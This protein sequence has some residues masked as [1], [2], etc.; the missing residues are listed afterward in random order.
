MGPVKYNGAMMSATRK[1]N[2]F[3][4]VVSWAIAITFTF[5]T[6]VWGAQGPTRYTQTQTEPETS[7][8]A[9]GL[10]PAGAKTSPALADLNAILKVPLSSQIGTVRESFQGGPD[11]LIIHIQD[12][13]A[14]YEVQ[15]NYIKILTEL[16]KFAG[17]NTINFVAVEGAAGTVDTARL[18]TFPDKDVRDAIALSYLKKGAITGSEY[19]TAVLDGSVTVCG[20]ED[21]QMYIKNLD[22]YR[23][24]QTSRELVQSQVENLKQKL[25]A[26]ESRIYTPYQ[27]EVASK[28]D[29]Y[30]NDQLNFSDYCSVL[31]DACVKNGISL[32][33]YPNLKKALEAFK[34]E[35]TINMKLVDIERAGLLEKIQKKV[36]KEDSA[37]LVTR[38]LMFRVGR[39]SAGEYYRFLESMAVK[40]K[41]NLGAYPNLQKYIAVSALYETMQKDKMQEETAKA[42]EAV[43]ARVF[44]GKDQQEFAKLSKNFRILEHML[45]LKMSRDEL[46]YFKASR[47][48]FTAMWFGRLLIGLTNRNGLPPLAVS[49]FAA[50]IE[51][52]GKMTEFYDIALKRDD[53]IVENTLQQMQSRDFKVGVLV[54]GGF[55]TRGIAERLH[56]KNISY[57]VIAPTTSGPYDDTYYKQIMMDDLTPFERMLSKSG[58]RLA[59]ALVF[60]DKPLADEDR[61]DVTHLEWNVDTG[62]MFTGLA[63]GDR[64][65]EE[66]RVLWDQI[67]AKWRAA[68]VQHVTDRKKRAELSEAEATAKIAAFDADL[69]KIKVNVEEITYEKGR[70]I[71][72]PFDVAGVPEG[73]ARRFIPASDASP[74]DVKYV[75]EQ[76]MITMAG[77]E[78]AS[79]TLTTKA[80]AALLKTPAPGEG[81]VYFSGELVADE[82]GNLVYTLSMEPEEIEAVKGEHFSE[83]ENIGRYRAQDMLSILNDLFRQDGLFGSRYPFQD[84][85][86]LIK[87][88]RVVHRTKLGEL[89]DLPGNTAQMMDLYEGL[90]CEEHK[91]LLARVVAH[92]QIGH[93]EMNRLIEEM[94]TKDPQKRLEPLKKI[95]GSAQAATRK[96]IEEAAVILRDIQDFMG[97]QASQGA[98]VNSL[99][100]LEGGGQRFYH[101]YDDIAQ[102]PTGVA[103]DYMGK[104]MDIL[105]DSALYPDLR[106][107]SWDDVE[108]YAEM[109]WAVMKSRKRNWGKN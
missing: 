62:S 10:Q 28:L 18:R 87:G 42:E 59:T 83:L 72:I 109:V 9:P 90:I 81:K 94:R 11:K 16:R 41:M 60:A 37:A 61:V 92:E 17:A 69:G 74:D 66:K 104:V 35:A 96:A 57:M 7:A 50:A 36:V 73:F 79:Q 33:E 91:E 34:I 13:H 2:L 49:D 85:T 56:A 39:I 14:N 46:A 8:I 106:D 80:L 55:H 97:D 103:I 19:F 4:R 43:G 101:M 31:G 89:V 47:G 58:N 5:E 63:L 102:A 3:V 44:A 27:K 12:S 1:H 26:L 54:T 95:R 51:H 45:N 40:C 30:H 86:Q 70:G 6:V 20:I 82:N 38:T 25:N 105:K 68:Y 107:A 64:T 93:P 67:Q 21:P 78:Y 32:K 48:E 88:L 52:L 23:E 75:S 65:N 24:S 99:S 98:I 100:A 76:D 53:I 77:K 71:I 29:K 15:S 84:R 108:T 22:A